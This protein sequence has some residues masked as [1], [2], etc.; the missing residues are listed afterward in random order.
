MIGYGTGDQ[1]IANEVED[2]DYR[3]NTSL[4]SYDATDNASANHVEN[5]KT[6]AQES[7][8]SGDV[9]P[10]RHDGELDVP[11]EE[12]NEQLESVLKQSVV[13]DA[14]NVY[15]YTQQQQNVNIVTTSGEVERDRLS[16]HRGGDKVGGEMYSKGQYFDAG[17]L[18]F[19]TT[20]QVALENDNSLSE[21]AEQPFYV[22]AKQYYRILKRRYARAKLEENLKISRARKPYLHES[23][24]KHAMKRPRGQGGRFLTASEINELKKRENSGS[25][26]KEEQLEA[27]LPSSS[28]KEPRKPQ[29]QTPHIQPQ[30]S[31][32]N[33]NNK[34]ESQAEGNR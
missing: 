14:S 33:S 17:N 26:E 4:V 5:H 11:N 23:R 1:A 7:V 15:L 22:N 25:S 9:E 10:V 24:H 19:T 21:P 3:L 16:D 2:G 31:G 27:D 34:A 32:M 30:V 18:D 8:E 29:Y 6:M 20:D 12:E 13:H 28:P